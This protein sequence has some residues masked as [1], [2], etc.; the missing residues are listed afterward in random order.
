MAFNLIVRFMT[1]FCPKCGNFLGITIKKPTND[2]AASEFNVDADTVPQSVSSDSHEEQ[3]EEHKRNSVSAVDRMNVNV[4]RSNVGPAASQTPPNYRS[5]ITAVQEGRKLTGE[6]LESIDLKQMVSDPFY[7]GIKNKATV[8]RE[9]QIMIDDHK[10]SDSNTTVYARCANCGFTKLL[11]ANSRLVSR[12]A[13]GSGITKE[14][15]TIDKEMYR[16]RAKQRIIPR[17]RNFRCSNP[18]CR[19]NTEQAPDLAAFMREEGGYDTI[20]VCDLCGDVQMN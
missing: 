17:T 14:K 1:S 4:N 2:F 16:I 11:E 7:R 12:Y 18:A 19:T 3:M 6:Q 9:I 13:P 5:I 15:K 10:N 20:F 8:K